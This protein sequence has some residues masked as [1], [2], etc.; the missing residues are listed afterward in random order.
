MNSTDQP[1]FNERC[2]V[3][4]AGFNTMVTPERLEAYWTGLNRMPMG[5]FE[6]C[7][8]HVL[9][10]DA[11]DRLPTPG[12]MWRVA[13][14]LRAKP[15]GNVGTT[16]VPEVDKFAGYGQRAMVA[17]ICKKGPASQASLQSMIAEKNHL[18]DAYRT[19]CAEEPEASLELRD[20]LFAAWEKVWQPYDPDAP[21][22]QVDES[23]PM[24][25]LSIADLVHSKWQS[26][27]DQFA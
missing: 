24:R 14:E 11:P 16:A 12:G 25:P 9:G 21:L 15:S 20:K 5:T 2:K 22:K 7:L 18:C 23:A 3:L 4:L 17:W 1:A 6:R 19:I 13:K 26:T 27:G 8:S 10:P